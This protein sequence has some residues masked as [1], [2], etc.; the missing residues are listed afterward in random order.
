MLGKKGYCFYHFCFLIKIFSVF[1]GRSFGTVFK[2]A[3]HVNRWSFQERTKLSSETET[4]DFFGNS[5]VKFTEFGDKF[6][7][8]CQNCILHVKMDNS[9]KI[10]CLGIK[11]TVLSL[12][13]INQIMFGVFAEKFRHGGQT[14]ISHLH[15][16][17]PRKKNNSLE[18]HINF[19]T[20]LRIW[21]SKLRSL[22]W[23]FHARLSKLHSTCTGEK[24]EKKVVMGKNVHCFYHFRNLIRICSEFLRKSTARWSKLHSTSTDD[25][26]EKEEQISWITH[27]FFFENLSVQFTEFGVKNSCTVVKTAFYMY[28]GTIREKFD[29]GEKNYCF[30]TYEF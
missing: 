17:L 28:E 1:L 11:F 22:V 18:K 7:H 19:H 14:C 23:K 8:G 30:I 6:M 2:T 27:N 15:M 29:V 13:N 16:I 12:L 21:A 25:P 20:V 26:S 5:I 3:F 10:W 24:F 4:L 9:R